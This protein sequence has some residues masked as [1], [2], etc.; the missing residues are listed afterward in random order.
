VIW[1]Q[2]PLPD[3]ETARIFAERIHD[4]HP[5]KL[6]ASGCAAPSDQ[7]GDHDRAVTATL[8]RKLVA[9]GYVLRCLGAS[10]GPDASTP[11]QSQAGAGGYAPE[12]LE[13]YFSDVESTLPAATV[14]AM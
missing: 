4:G 8:D 10:V 13:A 3:P 9:S 12:L 6:L 2:A 11:G 14:A 7:H 1:P 5:G